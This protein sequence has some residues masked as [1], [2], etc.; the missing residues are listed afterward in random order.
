METPAQTD[1]DSEGPTLAEIARKLKVAPK[2][3]WNLSRAH[4]APTTRN[5]DDW[6]EYL[7]TKQE[8]PPAKKAPNKGEVAVLRAEKL[9]EEIRVMRARAEQMEGATILR[10]EVREFLQAWTTKLDLLLTLKFETEAPPLVNGLGIAETR[11]VMR[12]LHDEVRAQTRAGLIAWN[13]PSAPNEPETKP[14]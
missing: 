13:P 5:L 7:A 8:E 6:R 10:E 1:V 3:I 2:L 4:D 14:A 9:R 12:R 11:V